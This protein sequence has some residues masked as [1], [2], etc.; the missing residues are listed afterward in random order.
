MLLQVHDELIFEAP[1]DQAAAA[2]D[3][4]TSVM[5]AAASPVL[6]LSVPLVAEAGIANSW[7]DAH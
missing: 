2:K 6:D 3:L 1:S 4:I 5:Q 7:A